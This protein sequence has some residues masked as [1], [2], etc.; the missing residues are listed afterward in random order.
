MS[1][2]DTSIPQLLGVEVDVLQRVDDGGYQ[3]ARQ[4]EG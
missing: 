4:G 2:L 3:R 1:P